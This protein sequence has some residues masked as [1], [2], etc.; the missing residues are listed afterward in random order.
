[1]TGKEEICWKVTFFF[2]PFRIDAVKQATRFHILL[3]QY[4]WKLMKRSIY[5][6]Y[7]I[8]YMYVV[9]SGSR[10]FSSF[11]ELWQVCS[12]WL[13]EGHVLRLSHPFC[14]LLWKRNVFFNWIFQLH[15]FLLLAK[16][17]INTM[18]NC[19]SWLWIQQ[20]RDL[21]LVGA[22]LDSTIK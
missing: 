7:N 22:Y 20:C 1:M 3:A 4:V 2:K 8:Y 17:S 21:S 16:M 5:T 9:H 10:R 13:F 19:H 11:K 12:C 14:Q 18:W 6:L 15:L